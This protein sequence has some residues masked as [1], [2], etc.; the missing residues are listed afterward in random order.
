VRCIDENGEQLGI[1]TT[2]EAQ[3]K[4]RESGLDLVE[5]SPTARPPVCRIM[6]YGKFKYEQGKKDRQAKKNKAATKVKEIKFHANVGEHDY[7]TKLRH[8]REFLEAGHR[9]KVSLWF[10]G[11]EGIHREFGYEVMNRVIKDCEDLAKVEQSPQ[12][13]GRNLI[14]RL[15]PGA[16]KKTS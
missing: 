6:D 2:R 3:Q 10:R 13:Y 8:A 15:T 14:M 7:D 9:I 1:I 12:L 5:I 4:A 11:R 16:A